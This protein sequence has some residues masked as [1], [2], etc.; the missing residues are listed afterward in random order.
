MVESHDE[1]RD[2]QSAIDYVLTNTGTRERILNMNIDEESVFEVG[3]D[4][5]CFSLDISTE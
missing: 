3:T 4:H 2:K 5:N 1:G